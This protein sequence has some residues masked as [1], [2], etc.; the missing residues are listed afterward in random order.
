MHYVDVIL[1]LPLEGTFT[2][3]VPEPMVAQV[4]MG[5]RV[6]V[7]LG[8]SKTYTAMAVQLHSEKPEF[9]TRPI[10]Q[11][12]DAEPVLIE[13]QLHLW[14]WISTYY[15]SPIGDVF[16]AALP[17]GLKAEENYRPKTVRCVT[18]PANLRSEQSLHMALTILKR[19]LKQH[20]TFTT[21]LELSHWSEIDG[22]TPPAHIAEIACDELQNAANASDAVLRQLIQRNFLE[23]YHR[24]VGRLNTTGEYHPERI[25]PLSPAQQAAEDSIR[26]QFN[27][28]NVVLLHGVTSSGKTEIYI[29]LIK[30]AIDEGKQVLYLL[31]EIAL[32][33][34]MT[35][36]LQNVF[37]SRL[38]I[39]HSKYSD[40]ERVE[41]WKKQLSSEPYDVILGARS[42][43][44]LPFTRLGFVIVDEEHETSFKQQDPAPRYHARSTAIMLARMYEGAKVLLGTATPSMES[45]HNACTGKYG[46]VQLT[47]R[48]KDVAMPE[49]RVVDTKDLYHRK[50]M[51]GAFS[52][53]LLEAMRTAL[54][55]KKQVLLFQ[56]RRGFAP[57][58]ECKVCGWVPKCK[59]CDVSLTYHR[60]MNLLTC[61]Y[62]GYTYPVP[63][64]CP[65]CESTE[66]LGRG[67]GTEKIEDRVRE[68]FPEARIAR[69]DLDTT[70]S[71][72]AYGRI[73]DDFS[74]GR[75]DILIGT[76]MITKGLDFSGVT[77][78]GIL[79]ADT[80]LNY[81]DFRAYEQAFQML[82][83][84]SGRAGRRD[85]RGLVILQ[86]KSADLPVIQQVVAGDFQT[87]ARDLLEERS[88]F[89]YPPFYHLV[90]VYL[91]HR[92]EQLVDSAAIEMASRL[93]QAFADRV[94]GPD[95]PAVARVKTESI[96]KIVIKLE[97]GI[98]LPLARQC[99]A[100]AR[101]QLL[102]DKRYAAMTVFFDVDPS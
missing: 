3:S 51:R 95:K 19:A 11:V 25:Q 46:Y 73:I 85:E 39:Y 43:V 102:Q 88:M 97:Q 15:M 61:H 12:I 98:N 62:C 1:P 20:Q 90:Y 81:P 54:R 10:I 14:Q 47:T 18:L 93:R 24:E 17:A 77:V 101:T 28:K 40:A 70:R 68:L 16:K 45:Y 71:A 35:R 34:Q 80:M 7:P 100:E 22:E 60:S 83:Q 30:K 2:Y 32:T 86:T 59:N 27:E 82:S 65:N 41:I 50:M 84:V 21:Y 49:I 92:N 55:N 33:V 44:F 8:R 31:P 57:M 36:R 26:E 75:T 6:L 96:R 87:F 99:M 48:Y 4:R 66:L 9:E 74:C 79:N 89:R 23:L 64:Q 63:K 37:G 72:G 69:M 91:R 67:Y 13:Q 53:D 38:G 56:N 58:V 94:L 5:V 76:Q 29:H 52:P 42:A 78:V